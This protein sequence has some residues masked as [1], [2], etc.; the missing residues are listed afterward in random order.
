MPTFDGSA[1]VDPMRFRIKPDD[2]YRVIPEPS[3]LQVQ[4]F[5]NAQAT[6]R[7]RL[8]KELA[9]LPK[10]EP[11]EATLERLGPEQVKAAVKRNAQMYGD[12][13]SGI[14][15]AQE[16]EALPHRIFAAFAAWVSEEILNPE[17]GSGAGNAQVT[18][19]P[20]AAAA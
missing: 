15:S 7:E 12:L 1:V 6:E 10:D 14:P 3:T 20:S 9:D 11:L 18:T 16:L 5:M 4:A 2:D 19:L 13:C 17:A 8:R